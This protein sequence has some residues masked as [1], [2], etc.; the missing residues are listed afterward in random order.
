MATGNHAAAGNHPTTTAHSLSPTVTKHANGNITVH[1][2][3]S[4][5]IVG[6]NNKV[7]TSGTG[8]PIVMHAPSNAT[9][10]VHGP[11]RGQV[12]GNHNTVKV[13]S[14]SRSVRPVVI[15]T[16]PQGAAA[17]NAH[18]RAATPA[19]PSQHASA[20]VGARQARQAGTQ[21]AGNPPQRGFL[22]STKGGAQP[23]AAHTNSAQAKQT[24]LQKGVAVV[25]GQAPNVSHSGT[26]VSYGKSVETN[27]VKS[28]GKQVSVSHSTSVADVLKGNKTVQKLVTNATAKMSP[29]IQKMVQSKMA[30]STPAKAPTQKE[31][32]NQTL[33]KAFQAPAAPM[34][35]IK[36][37]G[38]RGPN[39]GASA[40][41]SNTLNKATGV[42][43]ITGQASASANLASAQG[44]FNKNI[45]GVSV[46]GQ[47]SATV[48]AHATAQGTATID[49][50]HANV[51]ASGSASAFA[52]VNAQG[53][54]QAN[55]KVGGVH[56]STQV[57]GQA[58]AGAGAH[59]QGAVAFDPRHG[60]VSASGSAGAFA[61]VQASGSVTQKI[62]PASATATGHVYAGVG[63][64]VEG[65]A[66]IHNGKVEA[67]FG[68]GAALGVG[69]GADF[70]VSVDAGGAA[71]QAQQVA[72][73]V[74]HGAQQVAGNVAHGAEQA[75]GSVAHALT[76]W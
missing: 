35:N 69:A 30:P 32:A 2:N 19:P 22:P 26:T 54:A 6:H 20:R 73:N 50:R 76:S 41:G 59:A 51:Q 1:N 58:S 28:L 74:A 7:S 52:G 68:I 61:G 70:H 34:T 27:N 75:V 12:V 38:I 37:N 49:L 65:S 57:Q 40:T 62:G 16:G 9:V 29:G 42:R 43:T 72:G 66:G 44:S 67:S 17:Q 11:T 47:G 56:M 8:K 5:V 4:P 60:N 10:K 25:K 55:Y 13:N 64:H 63:A 24:P 45:K 71:H 48:G 18:N 46:S 33:S 23:T 14:T 31:L 21:S 39:A 53:S 15:K 36:G 3:G